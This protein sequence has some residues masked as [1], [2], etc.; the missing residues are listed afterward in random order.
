MYC[1][2]G[3]YTKKSLEQ[4]KFFC[5]N[6]DSQIQ[7]LAQEGETLAFEHYDRKFLNPIVGYWDFETVNLNI[8][9]KLFIH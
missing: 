7:I 8:I 5:K 2:N 6:P 1:F 9:Q 3:F 4:H